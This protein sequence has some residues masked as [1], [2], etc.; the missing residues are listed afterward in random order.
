MNIYNMRKH[1][2]FIYFLRAITQYFISKPYNDYVKRC[3]SYIEN[4]IMSISV[5]LFNVFAHNFSL[6]IEVKI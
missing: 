2:H 4:S 6:E 3:L 5:I 1:I